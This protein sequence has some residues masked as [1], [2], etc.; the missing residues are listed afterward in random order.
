MH[1]RCMYDQYSSSPG[2]CTRRRL[3]RVP[4]RSSDQVSTT[5]KDLGIPCRKHMV[6]LATLSVCPPLMMASTRQLLLLFT[7]GVSRSLAQLYLFNI[8]EPIDGL[9][10]TCIA[11][12]NQALACDPSLP[13]LTPNEWESDDVLDSICTSTCTTAWSTYLR[14]VSG[15][16][17]TS[18]YDGGN[19]F[20]YLPAI[21]IE[22]VYEQY[23]LLCL[24]D[25]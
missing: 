9:S 7:F 8:T 24:K 14:R 16:C 12:L 4:A 13:G 3:L 5:R 10:S 18:R 19:G 22:P 11:V 23:Q 2:Y 15:A 25:S 21:N 6:L 17:G 1:A 20:L